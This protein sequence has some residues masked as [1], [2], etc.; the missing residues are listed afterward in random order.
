MKSLKN[1]LVFSAIAFWACTENSQ[2]AGVWVD[3]PSIAL[4]ESSS[5]MEDV[6]SSSSL[7]RGSSSSEGKFSSSSLGYGEA[8]IVIPPSPG[9]EPPPPP[10]SSL[11]NVPK[12]ASLIVEDETNG[13]IPAITKERVK[14]LVTGGLSQDSAIAQARGELFR[15]LGLDSLLEDQTIRESSLELTLYYVYENL[16]SGEYTATFG[17]PSIAA[18][19]ADGKLDLDGNLDEVR[20]FYC[21]EN[22]SYSEIGMLY[23]DFMPLGCAIPDFVIEEPYAILSNI[24]RKCEGLP[25][26]NEDVL[27]MFS[28]DSSIMC[29]VNGWRVASPLDKETSGHPCSK[30]GEYIV[31]HLDPSRSYVCVVGK[32]WDSTATLNVEMAGVHC[33]KVGSLYKSKLDPNGVYICRDSVKVSDWWDDDQYDYMVWEYATDYEGEVVDVSCD[34]GKVVSSIARRD[35]S[36]ICE[37]GIWRTATRVEKETYGIPCDEEGKRYNSREVQS[38]YYVCQDGKW[39]EFRNLTCSNGEKY[40]TANAEFPNNKTNYVCYENKW[41]S[42]ADS[43]WLIPYELY[44]NPKI[45]YGSFKDPRDNR[46]YRTVE[47]KG[48]TWMAENLK[49]KGD[50]GFVDTQFCAS[51]LCEN[52]GYY[53]SEESA[54]Q[55][56]PD[57]WRLPTADEVEL[58]SSAA[59]GE[60]SKFRTLF[61]QMCQLGLGYDGVNTY[62]LSFTS[63]GVFNYGHHVNRDYQ[64]FWARDVQ[65][66]MSSTDGVNWEKYEWE[67]YRAAEISVYRVVRATS[68]FGGDVHIPVRCVKK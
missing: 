5:S 59:S 15:E 26:C 52:T 68:F 54:L 40:T 8:P 39:K 49:Y 66:Q 47:Y 33:D 27:G 58:L 2:D 35:S 55:A 28:A 37:D 3:D 64:Y 62:G 50:D 11:K 48:M 61:S 56:C 34:E 23:Q 21:L 7:G 32:G 19:L 51:D 46:T 9:C 67:E 29:K 42:S 30:D 20:D 63:S 53:Y 12:L 16:L 57:G 43:S 10:N 44:F 6:A 13:V 25:Y 17:N 4:G 14:V 60:N 22:Y 38:L 65:T 45:E 31:S 36:H 24:K 41:Y 18:D 1:L